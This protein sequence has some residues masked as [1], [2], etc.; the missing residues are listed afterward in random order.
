MEI[1]YLGHSA[2]RIKGKKTSIVTDPFDPAVTG[3]KIPSV[4][5]D[6]VTVSHEHKDH[7]NIK[8]VSGEPLVISG[9]GEYE[10]KGVRITGLRTYHDNTKGGERGYNTVY[11]I[12][13]DNVAIVH[14]GDLGHKLS[15]KEIEILDGVD[16]LMI[17]VGGTYT[18][19]AAEAV[20][21]ISHLEPKVII[22][23]HYKSD[24]HKNDDGEKLDELSV[25][26]KEMGKEGLAPVPK[27]V[28]S[29]DKLPLESM[30]VIFE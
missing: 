1:T 5:A 9:P 25:F 12:E 4:Q 21:V 26:L 11:R 30:V 2:F 23:M 24:K 18:I 29:K 20:E 17:P 10:V 13:I 6:I 3:F 8:A 28:I 15:D 19:N 22:P 14:L 16:I 7:N 27:L